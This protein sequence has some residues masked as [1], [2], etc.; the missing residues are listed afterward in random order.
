MEQRIFKKYQKEPVVKIKVAQFGDSIDFDV[1][2]KFSAIDDFGNVILDSVD[3]SAGW[4]LKKFS[5]EPATFV[6]SILV[7]KSKNK[8][9]VEKVSEELR[10]KNIETQ[11]DI[12]G[13]LI[14]LNDKVITDNTHYFLVTGTFN[15]LKE[16]KDFQRAYLYNFNT[17]I[18]M[19]KIREARSV[20]EI[21]DI[22]YH[23]SAK[24]INSI[25]IIQANKSGEI[26][27]K[28]VKVGEGHKWSFRMDK[29]CHD[30]VVFRNDNNGKL[31]AVSEIGLEKYLRGVVPMEMRQDAPEEALKS[32]AVASRG[33][34]ISMIGIAHNR[35]YFD[36]CSEPHCQI[37][38]GAGQWDKRA[39]KAIKETAGEVLYSGSKLCDS[40]F[41]PVCGGFTNDGTFKEL[42][43]HNTK[44]K[45]ELDTV[46]AQSKVSG[47]EHERDILDWVSTEPDVFCKNGNQQ[48]EK[49]R[50]NHEGN[51]FR[52]SVSLDRRDIEKSVRRFTGLD[53]G[54]IYDIIPVKRNKSGHVYVI[55]IIGSRKNI[56]M[57]GYN[58]ICRIFSRS[59][60]E[61][62]CFYVE[63]VQVSNGI[64]G[65]FVFTGAGEGEGIGM[66]QSGAVEMALQGHNY[67]EILKHYFGTDTIKKLY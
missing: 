61:S 56:I 6:F 59:G 65:S 16:A 18:V 34:A 8:K 57:S 14:T 47:L 43:I 21:F 4:R 60:L 26:V 28:G 9:Q 36:L 49:V 53:T 62:T 40:F 13:G 58:K 44:L 17:D 66:C 52:W 39:D 35:D 41:T 48:G 42:F 51:T 38:G 32:Q 24:F 19:E 20:M 54:T 50:V 27:L 67:R 37:F 55:E 30:P 2:G 12:R 1:T 25:R 3:S 46:N 33:Y 5:Y 45:G 10:I 15:S 7:Y 63:R 64:P 23:H 22:E 11:I 29:I 31:I